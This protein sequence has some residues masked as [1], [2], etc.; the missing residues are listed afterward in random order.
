MGKQNRF[1][2][3]LKWANITKI[4]FHQK[5]SQTKLNVYMSLINVVQSIYLLYMYL[6]V[7]KVEDIKERYIFELMSLI[8]LIHSLIS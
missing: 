2:P 3:N 7:E 6:L 4:T 8:G 5:Y 1:Q